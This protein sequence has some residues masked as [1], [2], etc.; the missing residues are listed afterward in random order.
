MRV[1]LLREATRAAETATELRVHGLTPLLLPLETVEMLSPEPGA[2]RFDVLAVTSAHALPWLQRHCPPDGRAL[3]AVGPATAAAAKRFGYADVTAAGGNAGALA[4]LL[5]Q[6]AGGRRILYAAGLPRRPDLESALALAGMDFATMD[7]YRAVSRQPSM[8]EVEAVLG[9]RPADGVML[10]SAGQAE[11]YG[12]LYAR[13]GDR[14]GAGPLFCLS[15]RIAAAVPPSLR[16]NC[17]VSAISS[18]DSL[19]DAMLRYRCTLP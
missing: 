10:L 6:R 11:A 8:S 5:V 2:G 16:H 4:D 9:D 3:F 1:L 18:M 7:V 19:I 15:E 13:F 12:R 17:V 14:V